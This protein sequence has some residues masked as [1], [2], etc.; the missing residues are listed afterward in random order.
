MQSLDDPP[1]ITR[2]HIDTERAPDLFRDDLP[3]APIPLALLLGM[4][5]VE[6]YLALEWRGLPRAA[7][8][9]EWVAA[10]LF[11]VAAALVCRFRVRV[12]PHDLLFGFG[13]FRRRLPRSQITSVRIVEAPWARTG[14]GVHRLPG[15]LRAWVA[16]G[17]PAVEVLLA[18][19]S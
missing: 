17:G 10:G 19:G 1:G 4:A 2:R 15:G 13:P 5:L 6:T 3:V 9:I 12:T 7:H 14:I 18:S 11:L 8:I 16:R